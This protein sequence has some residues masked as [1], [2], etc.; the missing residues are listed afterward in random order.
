MSDTDAKV[1]DHY[2]SDDLVNRILSALTGIGVPVERLSA[3]ALFP[4]DQL[5]GRQL[6]ATEEHVARLQLTPSTRVLDVGSGIGGPARYMAFTSGCSVMGIDLTDAFV[7]A[8]R[9]LTTRCGLGDRVK[10]QVAN[11]LAMPFAD[12]SFDAAACQYVAMNIAD[13]TMLLREVFRVVRSGGRF[14]FSA[15]VT[16]KGEPR[17]PLPW[18]RDPGVSFLVSEADLRKQFGEC[19]WRIV[20]WTDETP[21]L[22]GS[23][24]PP[25]PA[26]QGV[27]FVILG[28]DFGERARNFGQSIDAGALRSLLIVAERP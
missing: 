27:R 1:A 25:P 14:M 23:S 6:A 5:H 8:A 19:G 16:G 2:G 12:A 11:A 20:E 24:A 9:E 13:K 21:L 17:Y 22:Q 28:S 18:A 10:F 3:D 15:V 4:F 7:T 26:V